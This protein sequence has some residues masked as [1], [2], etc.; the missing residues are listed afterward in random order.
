MW[1]ISWNQ[2]FLVKLIGKGI[3]DGK[4]RGIARDIK[5]SYFHFQNS[6]K[7]VN[8]VVKIYKAILIVPTLLPFL[9]EFWKWKYIFNIP[10]YPLPFAVRN[11]LTN[12]FT[13]KNYVSGYLKKQKW[14]VFLGLSSRYQFCTF[15]W[16]ISR[17]FNCFGKI[18]LSM[19]SRWRKAGNS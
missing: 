17:N 6:K 14:Q 18:Y 4:G 13:K 10:S 19:N 16:K 3:P 7:N 5:K 15:F 9:V 12:Y 2:I 11:S 8:K 1:K